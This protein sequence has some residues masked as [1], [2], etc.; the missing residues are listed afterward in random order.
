[1]STEEGALLLN[2]TVEETGVCWTSSFL[3]CEEG[4][5]ASWAVFGRALDEEL[6][7]EP[8]ELVGKKK[9]VSM[10]SLDFLLSGF[11]FGSPSL[12]VFS[13]ADLAT[14]GRPTAFLLSFSWDAVES[15]LGTE[16]TEEG[17][18]GRLSLDDA[19]DDL[20]DG[21]MGTD[22][23]EGRPSLGQKE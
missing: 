11:A 19:R 10:L 9:D 20:L 12:K 17:R 13:V 1:M 3:N 16:A 21:I 14:G 15:K 8:L 4:G 2:S 7:V 5:S 23:E 18:E 6:R 22:V